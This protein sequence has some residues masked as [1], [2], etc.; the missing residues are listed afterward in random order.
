MPVDDREPLH[1]AVAGGDVT[2][3]MAKLNLLSTVD[4]SDSVVAGGLVA[5]HGNLT[6]GGHTTLNG[7]AIGNGVDSNGLLLKKESYFDNHVIINYNCEPLRTPL[8]GAL[9]I[10]TWS[11]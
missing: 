11:R 5:A 6:I 7:A 1:L 2:I 4:P 10:G 9:R 3:N 8:Q